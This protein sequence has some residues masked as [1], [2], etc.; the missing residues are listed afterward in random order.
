MEPDSKRSKPP[1]YGRVLLIGAGLMV[2]A[3]TRP[4]SAWSLVLPSKLL[5][6]NQRQHLRRNNKRC[7]SRASICSTLYSGLNK[8]SGWATAS[9]TGP[10][11][12]LLASHLC[13]HNADSSSVFRSLRPCPS[14]EM[15]FL[16]LSRWSCVDSR[17]RT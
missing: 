5:G 15:L 8:A 12:H 6:Q 14:R 3:M 9:V 17:S 10:A 2:V 13:T 1:H 7:Y 11:G 16:W 4:S